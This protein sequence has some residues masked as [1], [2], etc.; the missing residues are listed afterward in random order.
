MY[1]RYLSFSVVYVILKV[2]KHWY[3]VDK[4]FGIASVSIIISATRRLCLLWLSDSLI[5]GEI[6]MIVPVPSD[7]PGRGWEDM[8]DGHMAAK[9]FRFMQRD[10]TEGRMWYRHKGQASDS[11][12][13][14][15]D[16]A[17]MSQPPNILK[18]QEF[19]IMVMADET[20]A[21]SAPTIAPGVHLGMTVYTF[22]DY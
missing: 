15:F 13:F 20:G 12:M 10:I 18:D 21:L 6:M 14:R 17:D 11:D 19:H 8:G 3:G 9:M 4:L 16:V 22:C 7:G 2:I 5:A 1:L